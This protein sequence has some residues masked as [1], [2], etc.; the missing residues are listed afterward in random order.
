LKHKIQSLF[1]HFFSILD[2]LN[3]SSPHSSLSFQEKV[4]L[5][6]KPR[7]GEVKKIK[8][9]IQESKEF[10]VR[11]CSHDAPNL[12]RALFINLTDTAHTLLTEYGRQIVSKGKH[13]DSVW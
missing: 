12:I 9:R 13:F 2:G 11:A 3:A 4:A 6:G 10:K 1:S 5:Q 7:L 8:I